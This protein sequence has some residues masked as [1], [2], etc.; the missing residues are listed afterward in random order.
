MNLNYEQLHLFIE[1]MKI[2]K[3]Q[4]IEEN[5]SYEY[6]LNGRL[7]SENGK[8]SFSSIKGTLSIYDNP[9]IIKYLG[10]YSFQDELVLFVKYDEN[11]GIYGAS[12]VNEYS[13]TSK[14]I[15][16]D[17]PF[18]TSVY[19]ITN[20]L[21][22][23]AKEDLNVILNNETEIYESP[24]LD[25]YQEAI[26]VKQIDL[27]RYYSL[28]GNVHPNNQSCIISDLN[29][30][31]YNKEYS[32]AII[33]LKK[34]GY[35]KFF[36][37]VAWKGNMNWD[38][39][40]KITTVGIDENTYYKRVYFTDN[41]NPL[42][43]F[44]LKDDK[45][46]YRSAL[47]FDINQ[48]ATMLQPYVSEI[49]DN[50][51]VKA[52]R[53]QYSYRLISENGQVT[54]FSPY[55]TMINI[56]KEKEGYEFSG[57]DIEE[58]TSTSVVINCPVISLKYKSIQAIAIE[59]LADTIPTAIRD[60]G[61]KDVAS[62]VEFTHTGNEDE[63]T[64]SLTI[65][66]II[67]TRNIWT[68][69]NDIT[70]KNNK[71][72]AAG[73]RNKPYGIQEKY[74][75]DLFLLKG[76]NITGNTHNSLIN[77]T[78]S[79]FRYIDPN[80]EESSIYLKKQ[81][82]KRFLFFGN[83]TLTLKNKS[84]SSV[85]ESIFFESSSDQYIDYIQEVWEWLES[86]TIDNS[87]FP[88]LQIT[89]S[90]NSILFSPIDDSIQTDFFDYYF[91]TSITQVIID[92][93]NEYG[94]N[95]VTP[96]VNTL[97]YGAQSAGFNKGT[98]VRI[99]FKDV[100]E[101]LMNKSPELYESGP[102]LD[103]ETPTLKKTF[104]KDEIYRTSITF[105]KSGSPLFSIPLGDIQ[106][107]AIGE[108]KRYIDESGEVVT[109]A[110]LGYTG[111][112]T[113]YYNQSVEKNTL[114]AHRLEM[115]FEVRIPCEFK[116]VV[117]SYQIMYV[118]RT[119]NN[120]TVL[121]QGIS[122]PL[123]RLVDFPHPSKNGLSIAPNVYSKWTLPFNGGPLYTVKKGFAA[124]DDPEKG[125]NY[126]DQNDFSGTNPASSSEEE[127][128]TYFRE[129]TN[130]KMIY[131]DSPDIAIS[132]ISESNL[133]NGKLKIIGRVN[134]DATLELTRA[135]AGDDEIHEKY[136]SHG[137]NQIYQEKAFSKK[138]G[139]S[140]L[141]G[142]E[143][144]KPYVV[145]INVFSQFTLNDKEIE[146]ESA[147]GLL[148]RGEIIPAT[149]LGS[150]FEASNN[151]LSFF[152]QG[153]Y[154]SGLWRTGKYNL[155]G[156]NWYTQF[157][158]GGKL[159]AFA[160]ET[161]QSSQESKGYPTIFIRGKEDV[162][163]DDFI[164]PQATDPIKTRPNTGE[165]NDSLID[166][167][168]DSIGYIPSSDS[169]AIINIKMD[170][171]NS[172]Y[173]GRTKYAL[174]KNVFIPLG[175]VIPIK[176]SVS[177]NQAQIF[178]V[179][180]DFY[181]SLYVRT[182]NDYSELLEENNK[183]KMHQ[184]NNSGDS[185]S[186]EDYN[187][188]AAWA[189]GVVLETEVES[190]LSSNYRFYRSKDSFGFNLSINE[191]LNSAYFRKNDLRIYSPVPFNF[192]DD[193]LMINVLS[194]S[195]TKLSGDYFDAWTTFLVNEFY[196]LEKSKG[197]IT[198]VTNWKDEIFAI[199]ER[200]SSQIYIDENAFV[201]TQKGESVSV[202]KGDG[203][204]FKDH[205]KIS[206]FG[207]SIRRALAEGELGFSFLDEH[208]K[209][210]VKFGKTLSL[211]LEIQFKLQS[212][213]EYNDIID[214][215][216][217]YDT[218][219][220]ETNIR[221]RTEKGLTYLLSYNEL[222]QKFNG[223]LTYDNDIYITFDKRVFAPA[224]G[225]KDVLVLCPVITSSSSIA[226][227]INNYFEYQ[228][229]A[230]ESPI[231]FN[232]I[233]LPEGLKVNN[234][235]G[236]IYGT[237]TTSGV[238]LI[239]INAENEECSDTI[240]LTVTANISELE[241]ESNGSAI[242]TAEYLKSKAK[243]SGRGPVED[244]SIDGVAIV[245]GTLISGPVRIYT[246]VNGVGTVTGTLTSIGTLIGVINGVATV[247]ALYLTSNAV[248]SGGSNGS[249]SL[250]GILDGVRI[251]YMIGESNGIATVTGRLTNNQMVGVINGSSTIT[252]FLEICGPIQ[253]IIEPQD[254]VVGIATVSGDLTIRPE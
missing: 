22:I 113:R 91:E 149:V 83:V 139:Y 32:D 66:D 74:I 249:S 24:L 103:L 198:N 14:D 5:K 172:I 144:Q 220:K 15:V 130:R 245:T 186:I 79:E 224:C 125:E 194:A 85:S 90:N 92:I 97:V 120:R 126:N 179:Q 10:F 28:S 101:P 189:Y 116:T 59:Y 108:E 6:G 159:D 164:G 78:P 76:W 102:I 158:I 37:R 13:I 9:N 251:L 181:V 176:G 1:G 143:N 72:I 148:N 250:E 233:N 204:T 223:W 8:L 236:L 107:P 42:R 210:F 81:L 135:R 51:S 133:S 26:E 7:Y 16:I 117:D 154:N 229:E 180:G 216:G 241:G 96:D 88:N 21:S 99:S 87:N 23:N 193:P 165:G 118:E 4:N 11:I 183:P 36:S 25:S 240:T 188:G 19:T 234:L 44:N 238:Y 45:L 211:P 109:E 190:R 196:E 162:F 89:K 253:I 207:T 106:T 71:L 214:T 243:I 218:K 43:V 173:G 137:E 77:P 239:T 123:V 50:G 63:Y 12:S 104:V 209:A 111:N 61:V 132:R 47:E 95:T 49:T 199:Q 64:D 230:T 75:E 157:I 156:T 41:L 170:N 254:A 129:I 124:Y 197:I 163:T 131:F 231:A 84:N 112:D 142:S 200:E 114:Y 17:I 213:F 52:M 65:D 185:E 155:D 146:I 56:L 147:S 35:D 145:N 40:R 2:S 246:D 247:E 227:Q 62:I 166:E 212:L 161:Y 46:S 105:Y 228:I 244:P 18:G 141:A 242:V 39:N 31:E 217:Y 70:S 160:C 206:D 127:K 3:E 203:R 152:S 205:K 169:H 69:C 80:N 167:N 73:L 226:Y 29:V 252:S 34:D 30:Q 225:L 174:S 110:I 20:Q 191:F 53:V 202:K 175:N 221:I 33:I 48:T 168:G 150:N 134:S 178:D 55:S 58:T 195:A 68:Y 177:D 248:L 184:D 222:L 136:L 82:Y 192:K 54:S 151:A 219:Y 93:E 235:T 171:E 182:K 67:E 201:T 94:F 153:A 115:R 122:A 98:G 140:K 232:A 215:E 119:E 237:I 60:L 38:I 138:I 187:R 208:N 57:G 27:S 100:K 128:I 121:A 86:L